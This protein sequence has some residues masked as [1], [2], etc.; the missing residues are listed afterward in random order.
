MQKVDIYS[1]GVMFFEMCYPPLPTGMERVKVLTALREP[2]IALPED[3][4]P[5]NDMQNQVRGLQKDE[6]YHLKP[7][8]FQSVLCMSLHCLT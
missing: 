5:E 8:L 7:L 2:S 6:A 4:D 1:L 3:F